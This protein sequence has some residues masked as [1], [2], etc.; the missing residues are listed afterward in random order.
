VVHVFAACVATPS[1]HRVRRSGFGAG[2]A[3]AVHT[4]RGPEA[5]HVE[6][7]HPWTGVCG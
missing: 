4:M 6:A 1:W 7:L 5:P 3:V 2:R